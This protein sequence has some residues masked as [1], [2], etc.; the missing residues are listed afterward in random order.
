MSLV[1]F[2]KEIKRNRNRFLAWA[3]AIASFSII[4]SAMLPTMVGGAAAT[5]SY[6][7]MFPKSLLDAFGM[8]LTTWSSILGMYTTYHVFYSLLFGGVF[9]ISLGGDILSKEESRKTADFLLTRPLRRG[10]IVASKLAALVLYVVCM[11]VV[12]AATGWVGLS[13]FS[14]QPWSQRAFFV[15]NFESLL[16]SLLFGSLGLFISVLG[17][18]GRTSSGVGTGLILGAYFIDAFAKASAK[19]RDLGWVSPFRYVDTRV[20]S[21]A[22]GVE[23]WR[24][25]YLVG[26]PVLL[27][28]LTF[29]VYRR[30]DI[31]V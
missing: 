29:A 10:S 1:L 14:G 23:W 27:C 18:R 7:K 22:Y 12:V 24:V 13:V 4:T 15:L 28:A 16:L 17:K 5:T 21:P 6:L 25:L 19:F 2:L 26:V 3:T 8:D 31:L 30:K 11:N 9:A 20:T